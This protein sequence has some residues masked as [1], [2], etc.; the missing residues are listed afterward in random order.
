MCSASSV[1]SMNCSGIGL[2][3]NCGVSSVEY[4]CLKMVGSRVGSFSWFTMTLHDSMMLSQL[5]KRFLR[6]D[7][8]YPT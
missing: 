7:I 4:S 2:V 5:K 6:Q 3:G 8:L 1:G